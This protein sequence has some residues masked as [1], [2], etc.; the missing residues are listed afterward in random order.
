[1]LFET[2][3]VISKWNCRQRQWFLWLEDDQ[4]TT[5]PLLLAYNIVR[6][7]TTGSEYLCSSMHNTAIHC[8]TPGADIRPGG[9]QVVLLVLEVDRRQSPARSAAGIENKGSFSVHVEPW[10]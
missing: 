7:P 10:L 2:C 5:I 1:M 4:H 3:Q 9:K 8:D 6:T